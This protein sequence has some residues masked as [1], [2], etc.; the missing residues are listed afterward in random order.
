MNKL[1]L[2]IVASSFALGSASGFAADAAKKNEELT[3]EQK[4]EIRDRVERL[5]SE[6]TN[7]EQNKAAPAA[8]VKAEPKRTSKVKTPGTA[9]NKVPAG[10]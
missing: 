2:A 5:K 7:A 1:L 9:A 4:A 8:P 3:A 10:A 6:R